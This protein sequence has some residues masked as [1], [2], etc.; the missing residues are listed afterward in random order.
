LTTAETN[1]KGFA[2]AAGCGSGTPAK[3][4]ACLRALSV[5]KIL[6]LQSICNSKVCT[7]NGHYVTGL[8]VDG[9]VFPIPPDTAWATGKFNH[10]PILHGTTGDEWTFIVSANE[11]Y[12]GPLTAKEYINDVKTDNILAVYKNNTVPAKVLHL[13][14]LSHYP[15]PS[16]AWNAVGTDSLVCQARHLNH[17]LAKSA[18]SLPLYTYEF[19]DVKAPW[20]FPP[21]SFPAL[22]AHT[23][24]IQFL[25]PLWHGGPNGVPHPLSLP[26]LKLSDELVTAWTNFM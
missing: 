17:L 4:A 10:V 8:L 1:G 12:N 20:Y 26:Q 18:P 5:A 6:A 14:P 3:I 19:D 15:S 23:I 16:L 21:L 22:A 25:F 7:G 24:D 9:T 2:A 11:Y 13:Y